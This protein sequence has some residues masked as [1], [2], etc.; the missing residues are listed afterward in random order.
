MGP[1][2]PTFEVVTTP[3]AKQRRAYELLETIAV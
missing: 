3:D 1:G 2:A